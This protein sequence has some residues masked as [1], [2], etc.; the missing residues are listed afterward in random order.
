MN[1]QRVLGEMPLTMTPTHLLTTTSHHM[2]LSFGARNIVRRNQD[3]AERF[4]LYGLFEM[5]YRNTRLASLRSLV[6]LHTV[7]S[8][9]NCVEGYAE[10][11]AVGAG[12]EL[13]LEAGLTT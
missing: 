13:E 2:L 6:S 8:R 12:A 1:L 7:T 11:V 4:P 3:A 9:G 5:L 10:G